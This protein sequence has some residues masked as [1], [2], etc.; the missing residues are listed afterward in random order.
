MFP[1]PHTGQDPDM[2]EADWGTMLFGSRKTLQQSCWAWRAW[3]SPGSVTA[4]C[5]QPVFAIPLPAGCV[6]LGPQQRSSLINYAFDRSCLLLDNNKENLK[7]MLFLKST[8]SLSILSVR[9]LKNDLLE[10]GEG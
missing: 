6:L 2:L 10:Q 5:K 9:K 3:S 7:K 1:C 8:I 4:F